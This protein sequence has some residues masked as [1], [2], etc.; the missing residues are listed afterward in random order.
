VR[1]PEHGNETM[2]QEPPLRCRRCRPEELHD[3][4]S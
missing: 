2:P 4:E 1:A 3:G